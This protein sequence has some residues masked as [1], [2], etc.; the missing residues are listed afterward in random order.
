MSIPFVDA[1]SRTTYHYYRI[2]VCAPGVHAL[3]RNH[4]YR[5]NA[6]L[7]SKGSW[8]ETGEIPVNLT[9]SVL[10]WTAL[11]SDVNG[12][13]GDFFEVNPVEQAIWGD[14]AQT[15][16]L[17]YSAPKEAALTISSIP[18]DALR[19]AGATAPSFATTHTVSGNTYQAFYIK[20]DGTVQGA[21]IDGININ[22]S[23]QTI[24]VTS[25]AL[26][27][28]APKY[29]RFRVTCG[30]HT[31][32]IYLRHFPSTHIQNIPGWFSY[33]NDTASSIQYTFKP[34]DDGWGT[35]GID[36]FVEG[37]FTKCASYEAYR[38]DAEDPG[39]YELP[40][41]T[42]DRRT[43]PASGQYHRKV[44]PVSV[45]QAEFHAA[46]ADMN[47]RRYA[48]GASNAVQGASDPCDTCYY[49]GTDPVNF[50]DSRL[51]GSDPPET[52]YFT[53]PLGMSF[54]FF[55]YWKYD[56]YY[57]VTYY[58]GYARRYFR[59]A[60]SYSWAR[61]IPD[62]QTPYSPSKS[63]ADEHMY[64]KV[65]DYDENKMYKISQESVGGGQYHAIKGDEKASVDSN[66]HMYVIQASAV[67]ESVVSGK[68]IVDPATFT[69]SD[70]V[71]SPAFMLA[72]QLGACD[73]STFNSTQS[74]EAAYHCARY[75]ETTKTASGEVKTFT[76]WR[77]P[78]QGE[79]N[80]IAT[81]QSTS[82][83]MATVLLTGNKYAILTGDFQD[84]GT[85]SSNPG[86][87]VRC[88][89]DLTPEEVSALNKIK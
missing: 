19:D 31:Q 49:Y 73:V 50:D 9:Y 63:V 5:V 68:P 27:N 37:H 28:R 62:S 45:E 67:Q 56:N 42:N 83:A 47:N 6:T 36:Y 25:S 43:Q 14:G 15:V 70:N 3:E 87:Y 58:T 71:I 10:D 65:Y 85:P 30:T 26:T 20:N 29:I 48:N 2:P 23:E 77:L 82:D 41:V 59:Y 1:S 8:I 60:S 46:L 51:G 84:V 76:G 86:Y 39:K 33:M 78:T 40:T 13:M 34:K 88:V 81:Y 57:K 16:T 12:S 80:L 72:S 38:D 61:W 53:T 22:S 17:K 24:T 11:G 79:L 52:D 64:A 21:T 7:S 4:I 35:E 69:S 75:V 18:S 44:G 89:R 54:L 32:D 55:H 74:D 66:N